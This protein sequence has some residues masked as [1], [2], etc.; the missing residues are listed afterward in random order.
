ME[1]EKIN[2]TAIQLESIIGNKYANFEKIEK[3]IT[4]NIKPNV[5]ILIL[6]EL[7]NVG[8]ACD[9]FIDAAEEIKTSET[10]S[11]LAK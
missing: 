9:K 4:Q 11:F 3:L 10:I 7:W 1:K 5:D 2:I 6:P 8:W